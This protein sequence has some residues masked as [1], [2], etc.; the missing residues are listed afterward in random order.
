MPEQVRHGE[1]LHLVL[2]PL[3][4]N[5]DTSLTVMYNIISIINEAPMTD[6]LTPAFALATDDPLTKEDLAHALNPPHGHMQ[7]RKFGIMV[8]DFF[9]TLEKSGAPKDQ[10]WEPTVETAAWISRENQKFDDYI[11][12][13]EGQASMAA[14]TDFMTKA[15]D[16]DRA[17]LAE[18]YGATYFRNFQ[19]ALAAQ[20]VIQ[21]AI[22]E[23]GPWETILDPNALKADGTRAI[24]DY[25]ISP[26]GKR[27]V[28]M[29]S[30][31]GSDVQTLHIYDVATRQTLP[32]T[33]TNARFTTIVWDK[34]SHDGFQYTYPTHDKTR[35]TFIKHHTVGEAETQDTT[36]FNALSD[37]DAMVSPFRLQ[38]TNKY[39][40]VNVEIG[41]DNNTGL[42]FRPF[43]STAPF[44][45][46]LEPKQTTIRPVAELDDGSILAIT[47]KDAPNGRLVQFDPR[48]PDEK[49]WKTIIPEN[50]EDQLKDADLHKGQLFVTYSHD[51]ADAIRVY[52]P[53][54]QH[55]RDV[56]LPFQSLA[57]I[58]KIN[59][60]DDTFTMK[61]SSFQTPGDTYRYD[62]ASNK[63]SL[64]A[65]SASP[66]DL[67]D[68]IVERVYATSKDG[69]K[70]PY[71]VIR[72]PDTK[73]DGTAAT[74]LYG[75]GGF[76]IPL[77]P[78][79]SNGITQFVKAGG[80]YVQ[81][82]LRGGG[83]YGANWYN[84]GRIYNHI[85]NKQNVV[86][87]FAAVAK[88]LA[89]RKYTS[90]ERLV[91]NG[92]S[93]GGWLTGEMLLQYPELIGGSITEV[94]VQD[95][96]RFTKGTYGAAW[97]SD[98][99]DPDNE[100]DFK[101]ELTIS[102]LHSIKRGMKLPP[103]LVKT[104]DHDD[105]VLPW[106]SLKFAATLQAVTD[107]LNTIL[108]RV[109]SG[110]GHGAGKPTAKVVQSYA[111][112]YAFIEKAIGPVNQQAYKL[113]QAAKKAVTANK[114]PDRKLG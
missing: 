107:R 104:A 92:A 60:D 54:G 76:N 96:L 77:G 24:S 78:S 52:T 57:S 28:Y 86:D 4:V 111:E 45:T 39:E 102:P 108:L 73:L 18:R 87:D 41:T 84:D 7:R 98:Y 106:H 21:T 48:N 40:W 27:I 46:L 58:A 37:P 1:I 5:I 42:M 101:S 15:L 71:T 110:A 43:G 109:D 95:L 51:T 49:N 23:N 35:R 79:Y 64:V 66:F 112:S 61:I 81:A 97:K 89:Q 25:T 22:S 31:S 75:Y 90:P 56:P 8:R 38:N 6:A 13:P 20:P 99:G 94:G 63:L 74:K 59:K 29:T 88:D 68:A 34:D 12:G 82:N 36:V 80:I 33:V 50:K 44:K 100:Q 70:V 2:A 85:N 91:T 47:T 113:E 114:A 93:N 83:E 69:T 26:D 72:M 14:A 55:L 19:K 53:G 67:K 3:K 30:D 32:D 17:S 65:K 62:I 10:P 11:K 103:V 16:Y 9:R 105:R